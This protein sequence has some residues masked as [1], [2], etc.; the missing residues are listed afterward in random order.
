M[1]FRSVPMDRL[2]MEDNTDPTINSHRDT[3]LSQADNKI[4]N[5]SSFSNTELKLK[6][7]TANISLLS[8]YDNN[9]IILVS[10]FHKWGE[11]LYMQGSLKEALAVLETAVVCNTDVHASYHLLSTIYIQQGR[12]DKVNQL[13]DTISSSSIRDKEDLLL[14]IRNI[15]DS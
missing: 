6:Y 15:K 14:Q 4:L 3:I 11:R 7:G 1:L 8:E 9:Y 2:P 5:L 13:L 10:T 12:S